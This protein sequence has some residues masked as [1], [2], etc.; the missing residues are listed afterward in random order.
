MSGHDGL[1]AALLTLA[2]SWT[3]AAKRMGERTFAGDPAM[4]IATVQALESCASS[5]RAALAE[6][7]Q[8]EGPTIAKEREEC[9]VTPRP[10]RPDA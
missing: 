4:A 7:V 5:L 9:R 1:R 10:P 2:D 6:P 8:P 3:N